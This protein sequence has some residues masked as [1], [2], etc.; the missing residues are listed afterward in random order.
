MWPQWL[1]CVTAKGRLKSIT[2]P[3]GISFGVTTRSDAGHSRGPESVF[4]SLIF[5]AYWK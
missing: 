5:G 1:V 3:S 4:I 2:Q